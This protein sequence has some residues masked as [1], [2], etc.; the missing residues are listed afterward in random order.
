LHEKDL[1]EI[2]LGE[3]LDQ[4]LSLEK[5]FLKELLMNIAMLMKKNKLA[6][7]TI[8]LNVVDSLLHHAAHAK[9]VKEAWD[10][11][12]AT[13]FEI[14]HVDNRLKLQKFYNLKM[15]EGISMQ[16]HIDKLQMIVNQLTN[17][18]NK[19]LMMWHLHF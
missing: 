13:T 12:Y 5:S 11:L 16:V 8:F 3:L 1:W 18:E 2:I 15:E 10:N 6:C 7:G 9:S 4:R 17:I 19:I 14:L